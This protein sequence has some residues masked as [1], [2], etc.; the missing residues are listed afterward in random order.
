VHVSIVW[1]VLIIS[2]AAVLI[3]MFRSGRNGAIASGDPKDVLARR[4]AA[5]EID[6]AEYLTRLSILKDANELTS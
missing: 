6:E 4:Y 2:A 1:I 3:T 5:G